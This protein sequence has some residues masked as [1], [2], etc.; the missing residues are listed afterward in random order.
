MEGLLNIQLAVFFL[1]LYNRQT[2]DCTG[3]IIKLTNSFMPPSLS[4]HIHKPVIPITSETINLKVRKG[5][6]SKCIKGKGKSG[7]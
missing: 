5:G 4:H 3:F 1:I 6:S 7:H 2:D